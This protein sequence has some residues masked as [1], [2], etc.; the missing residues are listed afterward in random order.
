MD[1][2]TTINQSIASTLVRLP[3]PVEALYERY[4]IAFLLFIIGLLI[5]RIASRILLLALTK[6]GIGKFLR[7]FAMAQ[8]ER[9]I[10]STAAFAGYCWSLAVALQYLDLLQPVLIT[11]GIALL[12]IAVILVVLK[13]L[14][15]IPNMVAGR[16]LFRSRKLLLGK[17]LD[18]PGFQGKLTRFT[19]TE[20]HLKTKQGEILR[21]PHTYL[22]KMLR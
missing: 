15:F 20:I 12:S 1:F 16:T 10:A 8:W 2:N 7:R 17:K 4:L 3:Q 11:L 21:V 6:S 5:T 18:L 9:L 22:Q 19:A 13:I 14:F